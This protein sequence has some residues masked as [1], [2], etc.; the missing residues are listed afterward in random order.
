VGTGAKYLH[1]TIFRKYGFNEQEKR[2][3]KELLYIIFVAVNLTKICYTVHCLFKLI[4]L[5][6]AVQ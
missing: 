4:F 6:S 5:R 1:N 3:V 2:V